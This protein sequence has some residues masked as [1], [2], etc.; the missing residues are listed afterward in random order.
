MLLTLYIVSPADLSPD[1]VP[2][3]GWIDDAVALLLIVKDYTTFI[4]PAKGC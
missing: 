4:Q 1:I 3:I 2:V